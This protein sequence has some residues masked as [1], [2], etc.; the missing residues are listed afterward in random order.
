MLTKEDKIL[1]KIAGIKN[2]RGETTA[3]QTA[4]FQRPGQLLQRYSDSAVDYIFFTDE[5]IFTV[6][7][8]PD[9]QNDRLYVPRE[10]RM[11]R[12]HGCWLHVQPFFSQSF[13]VS[14][15]VS[16]L[17]CT[18]MIFVEPGDKINGQ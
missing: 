14:V 1:V 15:G 13:M 9:T 5:K 7:S 16:K 2:E 12:R 4:R 17:G 11:S 18:E 6:S 8:P 10:R 3:N